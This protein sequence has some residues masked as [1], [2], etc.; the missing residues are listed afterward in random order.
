MFKVSGATRMIYECATRPQAVAKVMPA[1]TSQ[2]WREGWDQNC[3][4]AA[5]LNQMRSVSFA[6]TV[7]EHFTHEFTNK[8]CQRDTMDVLM[9]SKLGPDLQTAAST[10]PLKAYCHAYKAA[11]WAI[12]VFAEH[13]VVVS[14]PHP[15]NCSLY[16]GKQ[17]LALPCDFGSATSASTCSVRKSL[18]ALCGGFLKSVRDVHGIDLTAAWPSVAARVAS[19]ELPMPEAVMKDINAFFLL[20]TTASSRPS[21]EPAPAATAGRARV[22]EPA[23]E[24]VP[25]PVAAG[26]FVGRFVI[27]NGLRQ[28]TDLNGCVGFVQR[29]A[30]RDRCVVK[31]QNN[32]VK[33]IQASHLTPIAHPNHAWVCRSC[34]A[35]VFYKHLPE[36]GWTGRK[37][38][39]DC[40]ACSKSTP[41]S[42][43]QPSRRSTLLAY[44]GLSLA[45]GPDDIRLAYKQ[46]VLTAHPDKGG[47]TQVFATENAFW[48]EI[49]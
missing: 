28:H 45:A 48:K 2:N 47:D 25:T 41:S 5:A 26:S 46:W 11:L 24:P 7:F 20:A 31:L 19:V 36:L 18:K 42:A 22:S 37:G 21:S 12:K 34:K 9:V 13:D 16:P 3:V 27:L 6:P 32:A 39:W 33:S 17:H 15:Y 10:V 30:D 40:P 49:L 1:T 44:L 23:P 29:V 4:E 38:K 8:W 14:D 43:A 35:N